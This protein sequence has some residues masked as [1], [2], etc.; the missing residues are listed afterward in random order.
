M[1]GKLSSTTAPCDARHGVRAW[2]R[3]AYPAT[4]VTPMLTRTPYR[5]AVG[6]MIKTNEVSEQF[7]CLAGGPRCMKIVLGS[8][9]AHT[10]SRIAPAGL[11]TRSSKRWCREPDEQLDPDTCRHH[12]LSPPPD[13][14]ESTHCRVSTAGYP[15]SPQATGGAPWM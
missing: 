1:G 7:S 3:A 6:L 11:A 8:P 13:W 9:T 2:I 15:A 12:G 14:E 4:S 5:C 10:D